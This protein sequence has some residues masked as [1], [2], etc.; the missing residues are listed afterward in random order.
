MSLYRTQTGDVSHA[1]GVPVVKSV[2]SR[3]QAE[4][5]FIEVATTLPFDQVDKLEDHLSTLRDF[6]WS[7]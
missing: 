3:R 5:A 4:S 2:P 1:D 6:I 7:R